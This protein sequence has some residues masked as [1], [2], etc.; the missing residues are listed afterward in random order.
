MERK[1][2]VHQ[3]V[4]LYALQPERLSKQVRIEQALRQAITQQWPS[5][6]RLPSHRQLADAL[7]VARQTLALAIHTLLEEALLKT[8]H[9]Q[10]TWTSRPVT[11]NSPLRGNAQLS[12]RAQRV[13]DGPGASAVQ[14]GAFVPGIPDI[15]QFPMRKWRQLYSSVTVPQNALLLSYSTGGYGPLKRA[16][17]DFLARWRNI[18]CDTEQ[19]II[20]DGTHNGIEL[21]AV[22]LADVGDTVAMES[23]CYWGARNVFTAAGLEIEPVAWLPGQGHRLPPVST[24]VQLAYLTGSHHYPLSVPTRAADK[25]RLCD[26]LAPAYIV[27][28]DYEFNRD[29]HSNLLFYPHSERHLLVGSFSKMMFPGLRLGYLVV[30]RHLAGPMNRLRSE[31]FRE[32]RMLDQAVLAQFIFDGD[33]DAWCRRIQRDYLGRQQV[34]HDQLRSLPLVRSVSPPSSAISL[35]VGFEPQ[36]NDVQIAQTLL[37]EHLIVRPLSPVCAKGDS[38]SGLVMGVGMLSGETLVREAQ[39]LRRCLEALLR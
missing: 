24:S 30:P 1:E 21:C 29:D 32:G 38:R 2:V 9:G 33:L 18:S 26:A 7:G 17:R 19:I 37:K 4:Q 34:L 16:I 22:A 39:R 10:G 6:L 20:T 3:L 27:E 14:S 23:P 36:V 8:A 11:P 28:D 31:L 25:Q 35:C 12:Q 13:L 15:A 5:G